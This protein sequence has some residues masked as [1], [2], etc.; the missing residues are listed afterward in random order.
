MVMSL[1]C[2]LLLLS[3]AHHLCSRHQG[4]VPIQQ[5]RLLPWVIWQHSAGSSSGSRTR[6]C[7]QGSL[8]LGWISRSPHQNPLMGLEFMPTK[9]NAEGANP[10]SEYDLCRLCCINVPGFIAGPKMDALTI[11]KLFPHEKGIFKSWRC[12]QKPWDAETYQS[13]DRSGSHALP[14]AQQQQTRQVL[15][16]WSLF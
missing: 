11:V 13:V 1:P 7:C 10:I 5:A 3:P 4:A 6:S 12:L 8:Q 16:V 9:I 2:H 15:V 14:S